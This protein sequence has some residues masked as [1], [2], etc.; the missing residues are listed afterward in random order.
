[1]KTNSDGSVTITKK[2]TIRRDQLPKSLV[3]GMIDGEFNPMSWNDGYTYA[4]WK[5]AYGEDMIEAVRQLVIEPMKAERASHEQ[6]LDDITK[7]YT[8]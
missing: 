6:A 4:A 1:M 8:R 5:A 7:K 2:I 3:E